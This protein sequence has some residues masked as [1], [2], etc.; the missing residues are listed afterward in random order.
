MTISSRFPPLPWTWLERYH[1]LLSGVAIALFFT[2]LDGYLYWAQVVSLPPITWIYVF[3][4]LALPLILLSPHRGISKPFLCWAGGYLLIT[5]ISYV[6]LSTGNELEMQ[7]FRTRVLSTVFI[8]L[9]MVI[10]SNQPKIH[11]LVRQAIVAATLLA[12]TNNIL[13]AAIPDLFGDAGVTGRWGGFYVNPNK[14]GMALMLGMGFGTGVLPPLLRIP[15]TLACGVGVLLTF[16]RGAIFIWLLLM[17]LMIFKGILPHKHTSA[18]LL[19]LVV[20][21]LITGLQGEEIVRAFNL[22]HQIIERL[23]WFKNPLENKADSEGSSGAR[24]EMAETAWGMFLQRPLT[25]YG[26]GSTV[27]WSL[28][29]STHN[30]YLAL[31]A[32]YGLVGAFLL[33]ALVIAV[34]WKARGVARSIAPNLLI[35]MLLW[36]L[37]SH[38][39]LDERYIL[40]GF[41]LM[42]SMTAAAQAAE[43]EQPER[44]YQLLPTQEY[45]D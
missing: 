3:I 29:I 39:V 30:M 34:I 4:L 23:E 8:G 20:L 31:M 12:I 13:G 1:L 5:L 36:G 22:P 25:G 43:I 45:H 35:T 7:E 14:A 42:G 32:D 19:G 37:F 18:W 11:R 28:P 6:F 10:F 40:T 33:P 17:G 15:F 27:T 2:D 38:N 9:M 24:M 16:S 21:G 44:H 26:V 41:A